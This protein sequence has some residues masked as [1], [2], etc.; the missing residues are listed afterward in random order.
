MPGGLPPAGAH[1]TYS[2]Q[3]RRCRKAGCALCRDGGKGHGPYWFAYWREDGK[4]RSRYLGKP[5]PEGI[6]QARAAGLQASTSLALA[7]PPT[8]AASDQAPPSLRVR[9][10]GGLAV[11]RHGQLLPATSW[12]RRKVTTLFTCL[13]S[14]PNCRLPRE[15]LCDVL[16]PEATP[17][18][19]ARN[20]HATIHLLR[21]VL[22]P[23][24]GGMRIVQ[25]AGE[26]V[27]LEPGSAATQV[28]E[29]LDAA[30]FARTAKQALS[31]RDRGLCR[32]AL[33]L[34]GGEYL[35]D[36]PYL[37]WVVARREE[38]GG[39]YVALL[40]HLA[41]LAGAAGDHTEAEQCYSS[42]FAR[43]PCH[44]DAAA[45]LMSVLAAQ[46]RRAEALRVYQALAAALESDL[47]L[48]P[49]DEIEALRGRVQALEALPAAAGRPPRQPL[50]DQLG[51][52]PAPLT[53]F[54][55]R[56]WE[57]QEIAGLLSRSVAEGGSRLL[58]LVGVGG[59]G[60]TRLALAAADALRAAFP[61]GIWLV[62]LA[63]LTAAGQV[64]HAVIRAL[65]GRE[66]PGTSVAATVS[67]LLRPRRLLLV[68]D[69][70]EHLAAAC[71]DLAAG[72]LRDCQQL[73][74]LATSRAPLDLLGEQVWRVPPLGTP[75]AGP[76][77]DLDALLRYEAVRLLVERVQA[78]RRDFV[79]AQSNAAAIARIC[80]QL[81]GLPL[82]IEL[83]AARMA[84][85][86]VD[87]VAARLDDCLALL[88]GG[89]RTAL[90][91]QQ[92]LQAT[93][94]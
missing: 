47:G 12:R 3:Y 74:I 37:D 9:T 51:N 61:D 44:E 31:Q 33:V 34:Y 1:V 59:S 26:M 38:L 16:W 29:W 58:T 41:A 94:E 77:P 64:P 65:G 78:G 40:L 43:D 27:A 83:A 76:F 19:A 42:V 39:Q 55:G 57:Q 49:S 21:Q 69:N 30:A 79:L 60:K 81:D 73:R 5:A 90:P 48:A 15:A 67:T 54:V 6:D 28:W 7:A 75:P 46:G 2:Q 62:E 24:D 53:S 32:E 86:P 72:L 4:L 14:A 68:L 52:L 80:R 63:A 50:P 20:L 84:T 11:W 66:E 45:A 56:A 82:A 36:E 85:L 93:M 89:N 22:E 17:E 10:L 70:C 35:P 18:A 8:V 88:V 23:A 91:R 71:A 87:V 25:L 92:T 13:L